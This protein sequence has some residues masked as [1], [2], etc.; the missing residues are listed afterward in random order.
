MEFVLVGDFVKPRGYI[1]RLIKRS[2]GKVGTDIHNRLAAIISTEKEVRRMG[3]QMKEARDLLIQVVSEDFLN[4]IYKP[5]AD[6]ILYIL[7]NS[8]C[9]WGGNVSYISRANDIEQ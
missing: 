6:P 5:N 2:G 7:S 1:E 4:D 9:E 3:D 8:I